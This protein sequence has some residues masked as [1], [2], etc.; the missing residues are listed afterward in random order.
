MSGGASAAARRCTTSPCRRCAGETLALT[1]P[2]GAGKSTLLA[3]LAGA[4]RPS[5]GTVATTGRVGYVPQQPALWRRLTVRENLRLVA[6]LA[7][8]DDAER[9]L[10]TRWPRG[11]RRPPRRGAVDRPG[12][13]RLH[14]GRPDRRSPTCCCWTSR[15]PPST[16]ASGGWCGSSWRP[17]PPAAA[18]SSSRPR[19]SR[20]CR[21]TPTGWWRCATVRWRSRDRRRSCATGSAARTTS[22]SRTCS[23]GSSTETER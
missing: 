19:T 2:N 10:E 17:C 7:G 1:G 12:A 11:D 15:P 8:A 5:S 23:R 6:R 16:R 21:C 22:G 20:R 14:R 4:L 3:L 9:V 18:P 13:A